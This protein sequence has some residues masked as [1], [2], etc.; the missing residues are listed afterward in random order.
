[1]EESSDDNWSRGLPLSK[2]SKSLIGK[3][4]LH[5][6]IPIWKRVLLSMKAMR[7]C[8]ISAY[9]VLWAIKYP[10]S[11]WTKK[12]AGDWVLPILCDVSLFVIL[13][14][15]LSSEVSILKIQ[16]INHLS[17]Y[18]HR[19]PDSAWFDLQFRPSSVRKKKKDPLIPLRETEPGNKKAEGS[20]LSIPTKLS[21]K[22]GRAKQKHRNKET[23]SKPTSPLVDSKECIG[24]WE[25]AVS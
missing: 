18:E 3:E 8:H 17:W 5:R 12:E 11:G 2:G 16:F 21:E 22:R 7:L 1:M 9:L 24:S 13:S 25:L 4:I 15:L 20:S 6:P 23:M 19:N 10:P 14:P